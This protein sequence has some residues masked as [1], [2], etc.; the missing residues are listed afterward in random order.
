MIEF[1]LLTAVELNV[2]DDP[3]GIKTWPDDT[4]AVVGFEDGKVVCRA[5]ILNLPC[6]EGFWIA[7]EKRNGM[8]MGE[9]MARI[10]Q[11]Y[12]SL[13]KTHMMV[14]SDRPEIRDYLKRL[15]F[16]DLPVQFHTKSLEEK[17]A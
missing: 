17:A 12:R 16:D 14:M 1:K 5:V 10:E 8:V 15:G 4:F 7:P 13:G 9:L 3:Q 6:L 2:L 11:L